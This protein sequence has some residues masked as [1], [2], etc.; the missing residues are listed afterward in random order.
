[1]AIGAGWV[2]EAWDDDTSVGAARHPIRRDGMV[3]PLRTGR[4]DARHV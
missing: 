2:N 4:L 3:N 1:M